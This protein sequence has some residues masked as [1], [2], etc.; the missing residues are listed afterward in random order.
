[1]TRVSVLMPMYKPKPEYLRQA[2]ASLFA[3][4][5]TDWE[6]ILVNQPWD[7]DI[8]HDIS[9]YLK[10][11]RVRFIQSDTLKTIGENWNAC[12][13]HATSDKLAYLFYDDLWEPNYLKTLA[14]ILDQ[15]PEV[16]FVSGN[17][18]YLFEG[19]LQKS[20]IYDEVTAFTAANVQPGVHE[21]IPFLLWW[22]DQ[23]LR[24][25]VIGE[26]SFVM[27]RR[28]LIEQAGPFHKTMVQF[29]DSEYWTRC[30]AK[31]DWYWE[32]TVLGKFRVHAAAT[33]AQNEFAGQ[34]LFDRLT[35]FDAAI[36]L[37]PTAHKPHAKKAL[38]HAVA[39]M[40]RKFLDR[41]KEGKTVGGGSGDVRRFVLRH[42]VLTMQAALLSTTQ[43]SV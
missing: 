36:D 23:G 28:S 10:D 20:P 7:Q 29:L 16:G 21:G 1:M 4:T 32:P 2:L 3:Q 13:P 41:K 31:S 33:T 27:M 9:E 37:L 35:T 24:P 25:N 12:L 22:M 42:P 5:E 8:T 30:L 17:R 26:P 38:K 15:H 43:P 6:A 34:G 18:T 14:D 40:I 19:D 39:A 11:P